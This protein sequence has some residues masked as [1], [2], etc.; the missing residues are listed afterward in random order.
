MAIGFIGLG[1]LGTAI[2]TRLSQLGETLVVYNRNIEKIKDL[3][4]EIV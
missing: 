3:G 1:N 4:Y 2:T